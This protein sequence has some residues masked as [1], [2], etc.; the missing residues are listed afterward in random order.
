M[1]WVIMPMI[2][3]QMY[4]ISINSRWGWWLHLL[5]NALYV[6]VSIH[7]QRFGFLALTVITSAIAIKTIWRWNDE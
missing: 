4:L 7:D 2:M 6:T 5:A 1:D 3:V